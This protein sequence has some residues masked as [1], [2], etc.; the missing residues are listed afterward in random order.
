MPT[1]R[2]LRYFVVDRLKPQRVRSL[3]S[4][5][6]EYFNASSR[7]EVRYADSDRIG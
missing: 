3:Q 5:V 2:D 6:R 1:N 7:M 4:I